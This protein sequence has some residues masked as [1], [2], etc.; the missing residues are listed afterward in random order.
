MVIAGIKEYARKDLVFNNEIA[1]R[2]AILTFRG[3]VKVTVIALQNL[4]TH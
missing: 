3:G 4:Y 1:P 2:K